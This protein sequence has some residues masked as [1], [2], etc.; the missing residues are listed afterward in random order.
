MPGLKCIS[1]LLIVRENVLWEDV[2]ELCGVL[3]GY[4]TDERFKVGDVLPLSNFP[5]IILVVYVQ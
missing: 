4:M 1:R 2:A 5:P 3:I